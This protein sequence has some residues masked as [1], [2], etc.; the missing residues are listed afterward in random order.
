MKFFKKHFEWMA[1]FFGL[2]LMASMNP[3]ETGLSFCIFDRVG[4]P[5]CPGEGLGHSIAFIFR[6]EFKE[7]L[8]ANLMGPAA[9]VLL[10]ARIVSIW[11][12][13]LTEQKMDLKEC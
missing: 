10:S 12:S 1:F 5:F 3:G 7:A 8:E 13:L 6:G 9:V 2:L 11:K 4:I